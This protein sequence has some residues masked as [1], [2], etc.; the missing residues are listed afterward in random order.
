MLEIASA[1]FHGI[2]QL[3]TIKFPGLNI[4]FFGV[5]VATAILH[6]VIN[7]ILTVYG[8]R[9]EPTDIVSG[10]AYDTLADLKG[11]DLVSRNTKITSLGNKNPLSIQKAKRYVNYR[12]RRYS[13][14]KK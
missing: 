2:F 9:S 3:F 13:R 11:D 5:F 1:L 7:T 10:I 12:V 8:L 6:V 14:G 4:S